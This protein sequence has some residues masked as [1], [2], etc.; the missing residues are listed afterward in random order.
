MSRTIFS[1]VRAPQDP[2]FTVGSLAITHTGR[3]S[4]RPVPVTTPSAG[5]S[6]ASVFASSAS[7][8]NE[9]SSSSN[10]RRS[11][12]NSL[13]AAASLARSF[14]RLPASA[15]S[16][17]LAISSAVMRVTVLVR[18]PAR[19]TWPG[20][21]R[22]TMSCA[23]WAQSMR[24]PTSTPVS[25]PMSSSM[26]TR[27][28]VTM[29][30]VAPGAYGQPPRPPIDASNRVT[31]RSRA[32][33]TL[34]SPVPRVLWKWRPIAPDAIPSSPKASSSRPTRRGVA[35]PVVSP[36]LSRSAPP[37]RSRAEIAATRASGTSPSYGQ[38]NAVDTIASTGVP[39][40]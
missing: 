24:A 15:R 37:S 29:L 35:I 5:R 13:F 16:V 22:P 10:A 34:A 3:P 38:P 30:P 31:P 39:A 18:G 32:A 17:R 27:S 20:S 28:S 25:T 11:R 4:M 36:K 33:S 8:T 9:P 7:S 2:A 19:I 21:S 26:C 23:R 6:S 12:T 40:A 1:T 14:S